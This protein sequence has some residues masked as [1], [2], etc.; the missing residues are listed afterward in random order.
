MR[1]YRSRV[2]LLIS[3]LVL[4]VAG[5]LLLN[6]SCSP[7]WLAH[8]HGQWG[9]SHLLLKFVVLQSFS[10]SDRNRGANLSSTYFTEYENYS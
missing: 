7:Q 6:S 4:I 9:R 10:E 3:V 5:P 2:Q 8:I 1:C